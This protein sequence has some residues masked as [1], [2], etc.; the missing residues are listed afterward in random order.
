[1]NKTVKSKQIIL[2]L[3]FF[4]SILFACEKTSFEP[5]FQVKIIE[6]NCTILKK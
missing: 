6:G 1:M 4:L 2:F 3:F 5:E